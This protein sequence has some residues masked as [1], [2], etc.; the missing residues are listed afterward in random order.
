M[1]EQSVCM[2]VVL[3]HLFLKTFYELEKK[4]IN[5]AQHTMYLYQWHLNEKDKV[6]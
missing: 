6:I 2:H 3:F 5:Q 4:K 1:L